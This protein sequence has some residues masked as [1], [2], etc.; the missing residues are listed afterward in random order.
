MIV[1]GSNTDPKK[2]TLTTKY[3]DIMLNG[4]VFAKRSIRISVT[5][6]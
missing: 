1:P 6:S 5:V 4:Y 2:K 3:L